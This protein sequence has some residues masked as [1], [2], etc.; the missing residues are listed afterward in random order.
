M[1]YW[2]KPEEDSPP[3]LF[4]TEA[5]IPKGWIHVP[6]DYNVQTGQWENPDP[7]DHDYNGKKGGSLPGDKPSL[8]GKS[9]DALL[10]IAEAEGVEVHEDAKAREI[11]AAIKAARG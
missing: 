5:S 6:G 7:L 2:Y 1:N 8:F 9:R 3:V 10:V 11:T 4:R